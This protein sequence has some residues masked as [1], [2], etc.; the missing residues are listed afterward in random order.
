MTHR[1]S[2]IMKRHNVATNL[3]PNTITEIT[4]DKE[5]KVTS[6]SDRNEQYSV[7]KRDESDQCSCK[8]L[9]RVCC[10]C[11]HTYTCECMDALVHATVCKHQHLVHMN[12]YSIQVSNTCDTM[13]DGQTGNV[14]YYTKILFNQ[15]SRSKYHNKQNALILV[16][17]LRR[18][19]EKSDRDDLIQTTSKHMQARI[20]V[21]KTLSNHNEI[22]LV[23]KRKIAPNENN[24]RQMQF[25]STKKKRKITKSIIS[26]PS[27][28]ESTSVK[29]TLIETEP[30]FCGMCMMENDKCSGNGTIEW[31]NCDGCS[32]WLH[33]ACTNPQLKTTPSYYICEFCRMHTN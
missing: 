24:E 2:E 16:E 14:N 27:V 13:D 3:S 15:E 23:P 28:S 8:I 29:Q 31:L 12:T 5:W 21:F 18:E 17:E 20:A 32:I 9:C 10:I 25:Y 33:L 30:I 19:I 11:P 22:S 1:I 6:F 7:V 4:P 26:K